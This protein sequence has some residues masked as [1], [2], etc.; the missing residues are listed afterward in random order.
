MSSSNN[1]SPNLIISL[2]AA[3]MVVAAACW[4]GGDMGVSIDPGLI[5]AC[6]G[7]GYESLTR[8]GGIVSHEAAKDIQII[9][10]V[11]VFECFENGKDNVPS[12]WD[13]S[14]EEK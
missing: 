11:A 1:P 9:C 12:F 14:C 8:H 5:G 7:S 2:A 13:W 10:E 4:F 6:E 3:S